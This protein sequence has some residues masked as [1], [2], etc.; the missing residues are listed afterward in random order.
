MSVISP[1]PAG[2]QVPYD[3]ASLVDAPLRIEA[4]A[5][6]DAPAERVFAALAD[7]GDLAFV[8]LIRRARVDHSASRTAGDADVGSARVCSVTGMGELHERIV[9]WDPP[10]GYA[11][12]ARGTLLPLT[13]HLG[14]FFVEPD[15]ADG[16]VLVWRQYFRTSRAP[17]AVVFPAMTRWIMRGALANLR[18]QFGG[19]PARVERA[20]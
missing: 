5:H 2:Q 13:V 9:L 6:F 17:H 12:Q 15:E 3:I 16:S 20:G 18:K 1:P 11:Y 14:V 8:P 7:L 19:P 10:R 4:V